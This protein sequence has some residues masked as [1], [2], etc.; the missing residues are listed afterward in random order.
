M[1][2]L[3]LNTFD[4]P[5]DG[6]GAE[7]VLWELIRGLA[8]AGHDNVLLATSDQPGLKMTER[9]GIPVWRAGFRNL[10]WSGNRTLKGAAL[11]AAWHA[12]DSYNPWM[13]GHL[14]RV[15]QTER[16][17]V[18]TVHGLSGWSAASWKTIQS[19]G[20]PIVQILHDHYLL[21]P[22]TTMFKKGHVCQ[23]QCISCHLLRIRHPN[24][25]NAL[26]AVVG[27]S[28]YILDRHMALGYFHDVALRQVIHNVR[29]SNALGLDEP[30]PVRESPTCLHI[31]FIGQLV[32]TKGV[33]ILID[34][35][36]AAALPNAELWIAGN[37]NPDYETSL[38]EYA[39]SAPV[40]F[41]GRQKPKEFFSQMDIV[42][43]PSLWQEPL[44]LVVVEAL[45]FGKPVIASRR[46]G[47]PEMVIGGANGILF[48]PNRPDEL[49]DALRL[50]AGDDEMRSRMGK[51][52]KISARPFLDNKIWV[53]T[54]IELYNG[55]MK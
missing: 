22:K 11:R 4:D 47:I 41:L 52:A 18:V 36:R 40:R 46:G 55:V 24:L 39:G 45:A 27:V 35:F 20:I 28:Q 9:D 43:V 8:S 23:T 17:D 7:V 2:I 3:H 51:V 14:R 38:R 37:G 54:Y 34:A 29:C 31:G 42:V 48:E 32:P 26:S 25:S 21:C 10:Y 33:K 19:Q 53:D 44:G 30:S 5:V 1:K 49:R 50:L 16:P 12:F 6:G 13:Q 15:L